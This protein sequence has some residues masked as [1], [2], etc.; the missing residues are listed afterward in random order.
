M[1][2]IIGGVLLLLGLYQLNYSVDQST[3]MLILVWT[4]VSFIG[5]GILLGSL[6]TPFKAVKGLTTIYLLALVILL[7]N[8]PNL[9]DD[10]YRF[11]WDGHLLNVEVP[12][13]AN[14]PEQMVADGTAM[15]VYL[16]GLY[17]VLNSKEYFTVYPPLSQFVFKMVTL[18]D[19]ISWKVSSILLKC[20]LVCASL[21]LLYLLPRI[22]SSLGYD[23]KLAFAYLLNPLVLTETIG[24]V[25]FEGMMVAFLAASIYALFKKRLILSSICLSFSI[26]TKL[27]PLI[28]L[29]AILLYFKEVKDVFKY[30]V[31]LTI[32]SVLV[33]IS[34]FNLNFLLNIFSSL[35]L[36]F[37]SF[38]FNASIY[39]LLRQV[40]YW[41]SG[42][43]QIAYL[44]PML[45]A[46]SLGSI[47]FLAKSMLKS[48]NNVRKEYQL[49]EILFYS[50]L[51]YLLLSTTVHP[52]YLTIPIFIGV[53]IRQWWILV[54]SMTIMLSYSR[55]GVSEEMHFILIAL[56][57][58]LVA[59]AFGLWQIK[60]PI[61]QE[62]N[63]L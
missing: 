4:V 47:L 56:E 39:Y 44:G 34:F 17:P 6:R 26:A 23:K 46:L 50:Y 48:N 49:L 58:V 51:V 20:F 52:W 63:R 53:L 7:F 57:Y 35:D 18:S 8:F 1:K 25:H 54:W 38:E 19:S 24:Q 2:S 40:G 13:L 9:S 45:A 10:I 21:C 5:Y 14:T 36:Y 27:L 16:K 41:F 29:P 37:Q 11:L 61:I 31:V 32:S 62:N 60:K 3:F 15:D 30:V 22:L 12:V 43:N 42:Y 55:Y 33:W 28:F 59:F